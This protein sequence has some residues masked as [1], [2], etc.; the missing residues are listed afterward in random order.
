[1]AT[2][3][4]TPKGWHGSDSAPNAPETVR[5]E[6]AVQTALDSVETTL[7]DQLDDLDY[8]IVAVPLSAGATATGYITVPVGKTVSAIHYRRGSAN[9]A[10]GNFTASVVNGAGT[11]MLSTAT[12]DVSGATATFQALTLTAT[13]ADLVLT[14]GTPCRIQLISDSGGAGGG[15]LVVR[16]TYA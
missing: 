12:V 4:Y 6:A 7:Q 1:M 14:A 3:S 16:F 5:L 15:P 8:G 10:I 2:I 13:A 11:T 9:F